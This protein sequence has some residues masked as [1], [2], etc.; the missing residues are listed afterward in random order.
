M[1]PHTKKL[2][3]GLFGSYC[4]ASGGHNG[5]CELRGPTASSSFFPCFLCL[6]ARAN[7]SPPRCPLTPSHRSQGPSTADW[8]LHLH[9]PEVLTEQG[10]NLEGL[11]GTSW[12]CVALAGE[13]HQEEAA[14]KARAGHPLPWPARC[15]R[16]DGTH[17]GS[18]RNVF[19]LMRVYLF[20][21]LK[22]SIS[23][24]LEFC[25]GTDTRQQKP[26]ICAPC[27]QR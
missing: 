26:R 14:P 19:P 9:C 11:P 1:V 6:T 18:V 7:T 15:C 21:P 20:L 23:I 22:A 10:V 27:S 25:N 8:P 12:S 24:I 4:R 3:A 5:L 13:K 2:L 16:R 17:V